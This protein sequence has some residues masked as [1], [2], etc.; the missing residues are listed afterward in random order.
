[1]RK[2][3]KPNI[4]QEDVCNSFKKLE[5]RDRVLEKSEKYDE[6]LLDVDKFYKEEKKFIQNNENYTDYMKK[7]YSSRFSNSQYT[8]LYEFYKQIRTAERYCP[9]CNFYTRQVRQLDHYLPKS[10][11]PSLS[12]SVNNLVPICKECNEIKDN[13]YSI[14]KSEQ[15][16]HPYYDV[17]INDIFEFLQ[18]SIIEDM[19]IGFSFYIKKLSNWDDVFYDKLTFHFRKLKI[20]DLYLSDFE[21]EF[22]VVFEELKMLYQEIQDEKVIREN[23][24]R[25]V[26]V[27]FNK[28]KMPWRYA[29]FKSLLNCKWFFET[30]FP[31]K[32][33]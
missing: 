2:I 27:Y 7:M 20:D 29:G 21:V 25:K 12:I 1:M 10:V 31:I 14:N 4:S 24:Q 11:F 5:Y 33:N 22:D 13:Y 8:S 16:I 30:Y 15:L 18:C 9:Y 26:D 28:K 19:N 17:Q 6:I 3:N 32:C 23:L